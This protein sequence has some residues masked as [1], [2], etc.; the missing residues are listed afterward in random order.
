MV[1]KPF[2]PRVPFQKRFSLESDVGQQS[3]GGAAMAGFDVTIAFGAALDAIQEISRMERGIAAI[4]LDSDFLRL[5]ERL[6]VG[7]I[8]AVGLAIER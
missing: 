2:G 8:A 3:G 7:M 1:R 5:N 4:A 6:G